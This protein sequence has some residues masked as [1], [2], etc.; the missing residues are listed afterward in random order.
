MFLSLSII[1]VKEFMKGYIE[2]LREGRRI[3]TYKRYCDR[4]ELSEE[5]IEEVSNALVEKDV[6]FLSLHFITSELW[7]KLTKETLC[8]FAKTKGYIGSTLRA[9]GQM[10]LKV[11]SFLTG[12]SQRELNKHAEYNRVLERMNKYA[13]EIST[14]KESRVQV[15]S[16]VESLV[17]S[18]DAFKIEQ[19]DKGFMY[20]ISDNCIEGKYFSRRYISV[21]SQYLKVLELKREITVV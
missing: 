4:K 17:P 21:L 2:R 13:D 19:S 6:R 16:Y 3:D 8:E 5:W 7:L 14:I 20:L 9:T 10:M 1:E 15:I 18:G 12:I 11:I